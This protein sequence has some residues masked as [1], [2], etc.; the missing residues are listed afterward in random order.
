MNMIWILKDE[1]SNLY[2]PATSFPIA[3][4]SLIQWSYRVQCEGEK[5]IMMLV[6]CKSLLIERRLYLKEGTYRT[7]LSTI[8]GCKEIEPMDVTNF[9]VQLGKYIGE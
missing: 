1:K 6:L 4:I 2:K 7:L 5:E 8:F 3:I 9:V